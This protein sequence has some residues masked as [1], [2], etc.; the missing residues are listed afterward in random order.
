M[1]FLYLLVHDFDG[2]SLVGNHI[3]CHF[4]SGL[5]VRYLEKR[6]DPSLK[7]TLYLSSMVGHN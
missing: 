7:T 2:N 4:D 3:D 6:P 1:G 5:G